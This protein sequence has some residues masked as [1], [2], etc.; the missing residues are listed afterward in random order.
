MVLSA[1]VLALLELGPTGALSGVCDDDPVVWSVVAA[2][3]CDQ[4]FSN[5][6]VDRLMPD[7]QFLSEVRD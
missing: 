4:S 7:L 3:R 6:P 2:P 5:P 1:L